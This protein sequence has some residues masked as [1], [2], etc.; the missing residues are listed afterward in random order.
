MDVVWQ[1]LMRFCSN[2]G[3]PH[4][5]QYSR[6]VGGPLGH[7]GRVG[8]LDDVRL[9]GGVPL[10]HQASLDEVSPIPWF[11]ETHTGRIP[12]DSMADVVID[13]HY[14][15]KTLELGIQS[16]PARPADPEGFVMPPQ[17]IV[18]EAAQQRVERRYSVGPASGGPEWQ[19]VGP[20]RGSEHH[21][22]DEGSGGEEE[23]PS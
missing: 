17:P 3:G 11:K 21:R 23:E 14:G 8:D 9:G 12:A 4:P 7:A 18:H 15:S 13:L 16:V 10:V 22:E 20:D 2:A 5:A 6:P 19:P 1:A